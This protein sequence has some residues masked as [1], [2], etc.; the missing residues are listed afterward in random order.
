M[1]HKA[2]VT[3]AKIIALLYRLGVISDD[4]AHRIY[5]ILTIKVLQKDIEEMAR[6]GQS[7]VD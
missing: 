7:D 4:R 2:A 1:E 3:L 5:D 6:K